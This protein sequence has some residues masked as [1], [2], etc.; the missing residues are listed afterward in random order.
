MTSRGAFRI[1]AAQYDVEFLTSWEAYE[2]KIRR[3]FASAAERGARFLVFPEYFSMELASL[4]P[5]AVYSSLALQLEALQELLP[6]FLTLFGDAA[7][8]H[9]AYVVAGSF[10]VRLSGGAYRNRSFFFRPDGSHGFQDKLQMTRFEA[11]RWSIEAGEAIEVFETEFGTI[12]IDVCYDGEF[13]MIARKQVEAGATL[14][15][16]PSCTDT[17]AGYYRVRVGA[18][19][20]ALENQCYVV[21]ASTVGSA[22][23]SEAVDENVGAA[24][25]YT[26]IDYGFPDD[27]VLAVGELNVPGWVFADIDLARVQRVRAE[28]QVFNYRDWDAHLKLR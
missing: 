19:A 12:G 26:P 18:Q 23:W 17:R 2:N 5:Q 13:P 4:F 20:R 25:V 22:P 28:G 6:R 10:P 21:Q 3:W 8:E 1:A 7:A 14:I 15:V 11:E 24:G 9:G 27:G 16:V